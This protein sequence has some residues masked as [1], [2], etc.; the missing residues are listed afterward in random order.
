MSLT[1]YIHHRRIQLFTGTEDIAESSSLTSARF[2]VEGARAVAL[3][4][5]AGAV[6]GVPTFEI[7][8]YPTA[9]SARRAG[10]IDKS[11]LANQHAMAGGDL[12][13]GTVGLFV[14]YHDV[15]LF[16]S[17]PIAC[18]DMDIKVVTGAGVTVTDL[19]G[20]AIVWY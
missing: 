18:H 1:P 5:Q 4:L 19:R 15:T 17:A 6:V 3:V 9:T 13:T 7:G 10:N 2:Q 8:T 16:L 20:Y 14:A 12:A 11:G